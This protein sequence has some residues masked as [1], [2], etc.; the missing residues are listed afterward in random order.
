MAAMLVGPLF[1]GDVA[2]PQVGGGLGGW[3]T[4]GW[5]VGGCWGMCAGNWG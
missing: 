3:I 4:G 5:K 1:S 2:N